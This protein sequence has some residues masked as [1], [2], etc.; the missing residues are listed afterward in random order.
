M[1]S[2]KENIDPN[3]NRTVRELRSQ[4]DAEKIKNSKLQA[5]LEET[6]RDAELYKKK[7]KFRN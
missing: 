4:L 1:L 2:K 7:G 5:Q 3:V 6:K